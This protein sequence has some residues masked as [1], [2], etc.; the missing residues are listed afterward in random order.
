[1]QARSI[2][3]DASTTFKMYF[4]QAIEVKVRTQCLPMVYHYHDVEVMVYM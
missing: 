4:R 1:M 3:K 2:K